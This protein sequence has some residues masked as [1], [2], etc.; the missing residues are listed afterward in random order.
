MF[1]AFK[2]NVARHLLMV[3]LLPDKRGGRNLA[4]AF[5]MAVPN[6]LPRF[7]HFNSSLSIATAILFLV[8]I[9][10]LADIGWDVV[11]ADLRDPRR[12]ARMMMGAQA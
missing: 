6:L 8:L 2:M 4:A 3:L 9:Q 11:K 7:V 12:T 1:L 5:G 10:H